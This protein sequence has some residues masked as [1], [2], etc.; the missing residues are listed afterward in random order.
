M[1]EVFPIS[2]FKPYSMN[3]LKNITNLIE[4]K[5]DYKK[6]SLSNE[7]IKSKFRNSY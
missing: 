7:I 5:I 6:K 2:G 1:P 3:N 4:S